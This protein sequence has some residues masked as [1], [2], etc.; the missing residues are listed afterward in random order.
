MSAIDQLEA[1]KTYKVHFTEHNPSVTVSI[2]EDEWEDAADWIWD[3]WDIVGGLSFLPRENHKYQLAPYEEIDEKTY[4]KLAKKFPKIDFGELVEY[5][6]DDQTEGA[7]VLAC[8]AGNC[9]L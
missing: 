3:N 5:E 9:E 8:V 7:K 1:W 4:E 2:G 6:K